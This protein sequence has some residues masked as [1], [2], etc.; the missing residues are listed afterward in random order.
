MRERQRV[1]TGTKWEPIVG[2]SRAVRVGDRVYVTGTTATDERGEIVGVGDAY[3][4][5]VQAIR[6]IERALA[7]LGAGLEHVVR[8][9]MFVTDIS[10]WEEYGRAH[11]EF[12]RGVMPATSM[13]EISRLIDER[14]LV[15]I[16][17]DA[18]V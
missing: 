1:S 2:Y 18:E 7:Q 9:R 11:G 17:A 8:T 6:N 12:F 13:I 15:E 5:A 16:E 3:A 4:Q 10:R 14:M